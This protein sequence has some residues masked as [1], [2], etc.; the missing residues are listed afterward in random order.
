MA[1]SPSEVYQNQMV[2][3]RI[4]GQG[5]VPYARTDFLSHAQ[6]S[7]DATFQAWLGSTPLVGVALQTDGSLLAT[8]PP[9]LTP[10]TYDL[11]VLGPGQGSAAQRTGTLPAAFLVLS[12]Q[13]CDAGA[14]CLVCG[15]LT[16]TQCGDH[17]VDVA[18][19]PQ[20]CGGCG[21]ACQPGQFCSG[22]ECGPSCASPY[23]TC[24]DGGFCA[25]TL[26]DPSNCGGCGALCPPAL[27]LCSGGSCSASCLPPYGQCG[28]GP[29]AFCADFGSDPTNCGGCGVTCEK[30][31]QCIAG[32]CA[33]A[34][35][36]AVGTLC[37][38]VCVDILTD[39][40]NCGGCQGDGG[41]A[42]PGGQNCTGGS[43]SC[44][45]AKPDPCGSADGGLESAF[46]T[47]VAVDPANCGACGARCG[48]GQLC[49]DGGCGCPPPQTPC[50][51]TCTDV[52]Q[53]P[54][55]CGACGKVC[56]PDLDC[57]GGKCTD[58]LTDTGNCL[59][60]GHACA[61]GQ[62]CDA[63]A[64]CA[65]LPPQ[66]L[67]GG[68]TPLDGDARFY[69]DQGCSSS[70]PCLDAGPSGCN[71]DVQLDPC[72]ARPGWFYFASDAGHDQLYRGLP[73]GGGLPAGS[74]G[75]LESGWLAAPQ[76]DTPVGV[77]TQGVVCFSAYNATVIDPCFYGVVVEILNCGTP[78]APR[79]VYQLP[80]FPGYC[81]GAGICSGSFGSEIGAYCT[82]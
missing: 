56:D 40:Q 38:T 75:T 41:V 65:V 13:L 39:D 4:T 63:T 20:N 49:D 53:D 14:S 35:A 28:A 17:C 59:A 12:G 68:A 19:D 30:G 47:D 50:G 80:D 66:C 45:A 64:G 69:Q 29:S 46:C 33:P 82:R 42:C 9:G 36:G 25:D 44:P 34:C 70:A 11:T 62:Y 22:G 73:D 79:Y 58:T 23:T 15:G 7:L 74:C 55:N 10:G 18:T 60:C 37:G 8:V 31:A 27:P 51:A 1:I 5:F 48:P 26:V 72:Y 67:D 6:S 3:V 81:A 54:A 2:Q 24:V 21:Q 57:C 77:P 78:G 32:L 61:E 16:P 76:G 71:Q 43:C 52:S